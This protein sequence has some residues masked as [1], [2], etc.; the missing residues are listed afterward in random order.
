MKAVIFE[1]GNKELV[2]KDVPIGIPKA[3][4]VKIKLKTAGLNRRDLF[5][6]SDSSNTDKPCVL[7]SDGAGII[8]DLGENV[9]NFNL[10]D[11]VI[12]NPSLRWKSKKAAPDVP[13][14]LGSPTD[15]TFAEYVIVPKENLTL[16]PSFLTWE[17]A[18]VLSLSALTAYRALFTKGALQKGQH[19]LIPGIG[20]GVAT[21]ALMFAKSIGAKVTVTSRDT[22]KLEKA[23]KIGADCLL[24]TND[25]WKATLEECK[26]DL[27]LDSIGTATFSKYFDVLKPNGTVV[28]FGQSSG[29][30]IN[31]SLKEL[32]FSQFN[33][34]GTSMGSK[35]EF[36]EMIQLISKHKIKP[37]IDQ[38]YLLRDYR[39]ALARMSDG[40]QFG[41][42]ILD[43]DL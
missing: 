31:L 13:E 34:L 20:G 29:A 5:I 25:D 26:V 11:E 10:N 33:I 39:K 6:I 8:V 14:I 21:F 12:I 17:E 23:K 37:I 27:I 22:D 35:E 2:Y 32:F 16:K 19:L 40:L 18:G 3:D 30:D 38:K 24:N 41:N 42:I 1:G 4:E 15:G 43:I 9:T 36:D 7:G 28:N